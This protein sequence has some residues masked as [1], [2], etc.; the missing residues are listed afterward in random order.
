MLPYFQMSVLTITIISH[1]I[2]QLENFTG[3]QLVALLK[4]DLPGNHSHSR[5]V[6]KLLLTKH[7]PVLE[8]ALD[9]L[10]NMVSRPTG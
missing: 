6:W 8:A 10:A 3:G 2:T 1:P 9:R 4:C 7:L 5:R